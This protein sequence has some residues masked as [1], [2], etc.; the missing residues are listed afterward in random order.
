MR[1]RDLAHFEARYRDYADLE[2]I[3]DCAGEREVGRDQVA[4]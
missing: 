4:G 1:F 2:I 3:D